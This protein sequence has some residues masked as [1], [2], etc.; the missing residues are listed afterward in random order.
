MHEDHTQPS[1]GGLDALDTDCGLDPNADPFALGREM[2][3]RVG[4]HGGQKLRQGLEDRD[5]GTGTRVDMAEFE[6]DHA[7]KDH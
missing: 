4:V 2:R 3:H 7:A 5:A 1:I 6:R